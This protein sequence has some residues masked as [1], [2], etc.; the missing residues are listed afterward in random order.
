M[1]IDIAKTLKENRV[2]HHTNKFKTNSLV[3]RRGFSVRLASS[4]SQI[5][6]LLTP[7]R[8]T[9]RFDERYS[10]T[11]SADGGTNEGWN[12]EK[13]SNGEVELF[14][15]ISAKV[16][17]Y[18]VFEENRT[19]EAVPLV[20]LF[21]P[22]SPDDDVYMSDADELRE[23][24][25]NESG[26]IW[27]GSHNSFSGMPWSFS[28][29]K[30][31]SLLASLDLLDR[32]PVKERD[33]PKKVSRK[34]SALINSS[35]RDNGVIIGNW[36]GDYEKGTS[37]TA[38]TGSYEIL[39]QY[40]TSNSSVPYGQCWVFSGVFTTVMRAIGIPSTSVSNFASAHENQPYNRILEHYYDSEGEPLEGRSR[41]STW[42][43]HV[44]NMAWMKRPDLVKASEEHG[45]D[46]NGW[47]CVDSTPQERSRGLYQLG[48]C[49]VSAI[50]YGFNVEF[51]SDF[52]IGEVNADVAYYMKKQ[53]GQDGEEFKEFQR[54]KRSIGKNMSVKQVGRDS[55]KDV[56]RMFK[57]AEGTTEER[58][59][60]KNKEEGES[61]E[62]EV[63]STPIGKPVTFEVSCPPEVVIGQDISYSISSNL[64]DEAASDE[65][66][67]LRVTVTIDGT[68]YTG[69]SVGRIKKEVENIILPS[70]SSSE[71]FAIDV[72]ANE[73]E[74][75]LAK[76]MQTVH[77]DCSTNVRAASEPSNTINVQTW[78]DESLTRIN[79]DNILNAKFSDDV[80][81]KPGE[82]PDD[83]DIAYVSFDQ[84]FKAMAIVKNI[85]HVVL[86]GVT[87]RVEGEGI[88]KISKIDMEDLSVGEEREVEIQCKSTQAGDRLLVMTLDTKEI[89]DVA[90][91]K[92]VIVD[93]EK[94][95]ETAE[96]EE[97][98][99]DG[100]E[101]EPVED[102]VEDS[103]ERRN[104]CVVC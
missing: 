18:S 64:S 86:T 82:N 29:F 4:S 16:G 8:P 47:Q 77:F 78:S 26:R 30:T 25:Q 101:T 55:R 61:V 79:V 12:L 17:L 94:D 31:Q 73:Y 15:S 103:P 89:M 35:D 93:E 80:V 71:S 13:I 97:A 57:F 81:L 98:G 66:Y 38:W 10:V 96:A 23:Y 6:A 104:F 44:W 99:W 60:W 39:S 9:R 41:G 22:Y 90:R 52:V 69:K 76:G 24:I 88:T 21:N 74:S 27:R 63:E 28:Q 2:A 50:K 75:L 40:W 11:V 85:S 68:D 3:A 65:D 95:A 45:L 51:D 83:G 59:S 1:T 84:Q 91:S 36:S 5:T 58:I 37:P 20:V 67:N 72:T 56:T 70:S 62:P 48:P 32:I 43:F 53:D 14:I 100:E 92:H 19:S 7:V 87:L 42:N 46:Y 49:P 34:L 33:D 102:L 54:N